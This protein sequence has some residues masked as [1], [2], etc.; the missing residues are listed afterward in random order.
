MNN[1]E[2]NNCFFIQP[3]QT[4]LLSIFLAI[5]YIRVKVVRNTIGELADMLTQVLSDLNADQKTID[6]YTLSKSGTKL[7]HQAMILDNEVVLDLANMFSQHNWIL[8]KNNT[9]M[10]FFTSDNPIGTI[11]HIKHPYL[12]MGGIASKGVEV[13]FPVSPDLLLI[14]LEKTYHSKSESKH[15]RII[16]I[17][18]TKIIEH[19]NIHC[20]IN[21]GRCTFSQKNDFSIV[22]R[23]KAMNPDVLHVPKATLSWGEKTYTP[24]KK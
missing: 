1:W 23:M 8:L 7:L 18:D 10:P 11:A 19:Y 17:D 6:K 22:K 21:S 14:M 20:I 16:E 12:S 2:I 3:E 13:F 4:A 15:C 5:Q 9:A 24:S